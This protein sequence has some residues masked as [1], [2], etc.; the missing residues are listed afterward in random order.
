[1]A[2]KKPAAKKK[3]G[4]QTAAQKRAQE[5]RSATRKKAKAK[6]APP[7][8][9]LSPAELAKPQKKTSRAN[10]R[11]AKTAATKNRVKKSGL[12]SRVLG[13][14]SARGRRAQGRRDSKG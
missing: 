2:K 6:L 4:G 12:D 5:I 8:E 14:V 13:H 7:A 11:K 3:V 9:E 10:Q 1:M